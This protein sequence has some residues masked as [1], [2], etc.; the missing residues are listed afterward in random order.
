MINQ[1]LLPDFVV[2]GAG[3]SG[4]TSLDHYL[5]QHPKIFMSPIKEPDF[6]AYEKFDPSGL[7]GRDLAH[8]DRAIKTIEDYQKLFCGAEK[9]Q[10]KG[11]ISN[12]CLSSPLAAERMKHYIPDARLIAILRQPTDRLFSRHMHLLRINRS[13][14]EF[15]DVVDPGSIGWKR[16]DLIPEGFYARNLKRFYDLYPRES[17]MVILTEELKSDP[18]GVMKRIFEHIGAAPFTNIDFSV[19]HNR[20]GVVRNKFYDRTIGSNSV[21]KKAI[22]DLLPETAYSKVTKVPMLQ[23][24]TQRI[25]NA[26]LE[27][28]ERDSDLLRRINSEVYYNEI[29]D[30]SRLLDRDLQKW[31]DYPAE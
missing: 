26:N 13:P 18:E 5:S 14:G 19:I 6:F 22:K 1:L 17:I 9:G 23:R 24:M 12:T 21:I 20:S 25:N 11:E 30:L 10:I 29:K 2:I 4:T 16:K 3:K 15:E 27:V 28:P 31:L 8:Y 7:S